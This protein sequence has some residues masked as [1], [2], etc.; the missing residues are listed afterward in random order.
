MTQLSNVVAQRL[1]CTAH[2][3]DVCPQGCQFDDALPQIQYLGPVSRDL[4]C[5]TATWR[6]RL[7]RHVF[8]ITHKCPS[9]DVGLVC[10]QT[11]RA[12]IK[13]G[14]EC[15][16]VVTLTRRLLYGDVLTLNPDAVSAR[17][18]FRYNHVDYWPS[19]TPLP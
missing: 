12:V 1:Y 6:C 3:P 11:S 9:C 16:P 19:T 15:D 17:K 7:C 4:A 2:G 10:Y 14:T 8:Q 18:P 5:R 13:P